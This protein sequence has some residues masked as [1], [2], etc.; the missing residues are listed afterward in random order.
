MKKYKMLQRGLLHEASKV[1]V[2]RVPASLGNGIP[3]HALEV[4]RLAVDEQ[5]L[6]L[7]R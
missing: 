6:S 1:Q 7:V 2:L 5:L 3:G 4:Q